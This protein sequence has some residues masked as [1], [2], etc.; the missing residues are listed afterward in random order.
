MA[1]EGDGE[2]RRGAEVDEAIDCG[3]LPEDEEERSEGP[4]EGQEWTVG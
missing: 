2:G 1:E 3:A 4:D